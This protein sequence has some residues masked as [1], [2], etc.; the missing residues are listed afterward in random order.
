MVAALPQ[1]ISAFL[2]FI[3]SN[4]PAILQAG[5]SILTNLIAGIANTIP[6]LATEAGKVVSTITNKIGELPSKA[7]QWGKDLISNFVNGIKNSIGKVT[8]AVTS[9]ANKVA[10]F[11]GFS[12]PEEGPLSN[13]HTYAPD[14]MKLFA[15]GIRDN[16][17]LVQD[18][19]NKS[20]DFDFG[21]A[22]VDFSSSSLG[23]SQAGFSGAL[24][25]MAA[26][27]GQNFTITVQSV[28]DGKV[29]GETAYQYSR[30]KARAYGG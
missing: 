21:T 5:V 24:N 17:H 29:I 16:A 26:T 12:E 28:L 23:R 7:L 22:N 30:N 27:M 13:F 25:S 14:M 19:L 1:I 18:Q 11:I 8:S 6:K 9:V 15:Q 4:L 10:D 20:L 3:V 2:N